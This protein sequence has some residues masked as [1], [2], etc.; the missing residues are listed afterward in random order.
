MTPSL[1]QETSSQSIHMLIVILILSLYVLNF[2]FDLAFI[3]KLTLSLQV[4]MTFLPGDSL[5][6]KPKDEEDIWR[7]IKDE[8]MYYLEGSLQLY[9]L[10]H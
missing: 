3:S 10:L 2:H 4:A 9:V 1:K 7:I 5:C 6:K 8:G